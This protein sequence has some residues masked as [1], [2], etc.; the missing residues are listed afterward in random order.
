MSSIVKISFML[1]FIESIISFTKGKVI[2]S[3][4]FVNLHLE[5]FSTDRPVFNVFSIAQ[6]IVPRHGENGK[7]SRYGN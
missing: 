6:N 3:K 5:L 7:I 4:I 2:Q 1:E